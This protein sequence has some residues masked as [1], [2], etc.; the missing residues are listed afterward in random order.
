MGHPS[1]T[2]WGAQITF[3]S[4]QSAMKGF[5]GLFFKCRI[6]VGQ[7]VG[8]APSCSA[9][10]CQFCVFAQNTNG[11]ST[12]CLAFCHRKIQFLCKLWEISCARTIQVESS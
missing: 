3:L 4:L 8:A 9:A 10:P 12:P 7:K 5:V 11:C 6:V 1:S 2:G